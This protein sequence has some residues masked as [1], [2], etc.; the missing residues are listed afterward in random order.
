MNGAPLW[1]P[2]VDG[3]LREQTLRVAHALARALEDVLPHRAPDASLAT[4]DTGLALLFT[5]LDRVQPSEHH[6]A[7][8]R[9]LLDDAMEAVAS[10]PMGMA[11]H[12]G[13]SGVAW[14]LEHVH[15]GGAEEEG[16]ALE[17]VDAALAQRLA[18]SPWTAPQDLITGLVGL[19][20]YALERLPRADARRCLED[21]VARLAESAETCPEG[22]TWKTLPRWLPEA[23]R[24]EL[25]DGRHDLGVAHGVPGIIVVLAGA[26]RAGVAEPEARRLLHGAWSWVMAQ[27]LPHAGRRF[28]Y[29]HIPG[30]T[31]KPTRAAW[32]YGDPGVSL[33]L[34]TAARAVREPAWEAEALE[35]A[36]EAARRTMDDSGVKDAPLCHGAAGL[37]HIYNRFHQAT[38]EEVFASTA[39]QWLE[40][41]LRQRQPDRG[42]GG[43]AFWSQDDQ[44][45]S[46]WVDRPGLLEGTAGIALAL[47]AAASSVEPSWDRVLLMS[48]RDVAPETTP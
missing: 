6:A 21:V 20:V 27:R 11:L 25:P 30:R 9:R 10:R 44:G 2:L 26:A 14:A 36:R 5:W 13:V 37:L 12:S 8:A 1:R 7:L 43:Y 41:T 32:C 18:V 39:R 45:A 23:Q 42:I 40:H 35:L 29:A 38:G 48:L 4:G 17:D 28:P 16:D 19:G 15:G 46:S 31:P 3:A 24:R 34:F 47:L 33:A 22:L